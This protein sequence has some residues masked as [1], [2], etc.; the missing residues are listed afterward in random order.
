MSYPQETGLALLISGPPELISFWSEQMYKIKAVLRQ[1]GEG[2]GNPLQ[3]SCL[4]NPMDR[5]AERKLTLN[6]HW[7]A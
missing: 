4:A 2:N 6:V 5:G 1:Y 7:K 3:Y